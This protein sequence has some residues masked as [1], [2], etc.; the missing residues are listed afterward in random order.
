[1]F[2]ETSLAW[3]WVRFVSIDL[4]LN[5]IVEL[6]E[7][8]KHYLLMDIKA[9]IMLN[10]RN[11]RHSRSSDF[12]FIVSFHRWLM[13]MKLSL[14]AEVSRCYWVCTQEPTSSLTKRFRKSKSP[15][16]SPKV[17]F[18]ALFLVIYASWEK[19]RTS[20]RNLLSLNNWK[21]PFACILCQRTLAFLFS[22]PDTKRKRSRRTKR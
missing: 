14:F 16:N 22:F 1:M 5:L 21:S 7:Q 3:L 20:F 12:C 15:E 6:H 2:S 10:G 18:I 4:F 19:L 8:L 17:T 13:R 9:F 11:N